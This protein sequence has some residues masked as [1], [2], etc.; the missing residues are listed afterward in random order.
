MSTLAVPLTL[1][2]DNSPLVEGT[3][4]GEVSNVVEVS[5]G[6]DR[7]IDIANTSTGAPV[8]TRTGVSLQSYSVYTFF[9][10]DNGGTAIGVLRRDR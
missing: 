2:L 1:S 9:M 5:S 8:L 6:T 4:L 3:L 10:T 7:Q